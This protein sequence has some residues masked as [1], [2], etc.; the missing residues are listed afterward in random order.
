MDFQDVKEKIRSIISNI[1]SKFSKNDSNENSTTQSNDNNEMLSIDD[2]FSPGSSTVKKDSKPTSKNNGGSD[3]LKKS[4]DAAKTF[5]NSADYNPFADQEEVI[6]VDRKEFKENWFK[7][8]IKSF[9]MILMLFLAALCSI[10]IYKL[11]YSLLNNTDVTSIGSYSDYLVPEGNLSPTINENDLII[12]QNHEFYGIGDIILYEFAGTSHKIGKVTDIIRGY[13]I[14]TDNNIK[15]G[16]Y[17][18]KISE[19]LVIGKEV[20]TIKNFKGIYNFITSPLTIFFAV[21][22]IAL[23]FYLISKGKIKDDKGII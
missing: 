21:G 12:V 20:K 14:I 5:I 19:S 11:G 23:Y 3:I 8:F 18:S 17:N 16:D 9:I 4:L 7:I 1:K 6:K 15:V 22:L 2:Y 10:M 13:Y